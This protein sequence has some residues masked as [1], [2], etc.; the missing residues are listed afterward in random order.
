MRKV[1]L[2]AVVATLAACAEAEKAPEAT[3]IAGATETASTAPAQAASWKL[4]AGTYEYTRADGTSG[5]TTVAAD[6]TYS[7]KPATGETETGTWAEEAG[8]TCLKSNGTPE[9][10]RC[11][12]FTTPDGEG[13]LTGTSEEV[14]VTKIRKTA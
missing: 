13:N 2:L 1:V 6:G 4:E 10:R 3:E 12:V 14:G 9:N 8:K 5:V 11:Y 7:M